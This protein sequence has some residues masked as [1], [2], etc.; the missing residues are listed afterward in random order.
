MPAMMIPY[1]WLLLSIIFEV[2][3]TSL[4]P[5]TQNFRR[6]SI[7]ALVLTL[8]FLC[9][10]TLSQAMMVLSVSLAYALWSGLGIVL[11]NIV[12][13]VYYRQKIDRWGFAGLLLIVSGCI[14]M[15]VMQ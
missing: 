4:L 10:F 6:V 9:F 2:L 13:V 5:K 3:A 12:G 7:T 8:Y 1:A 14:T 15:G 11:I